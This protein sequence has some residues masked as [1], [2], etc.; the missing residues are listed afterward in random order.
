MWVIGAQ[1]AGKSSLINALRRDFKQ[2]AHCDGDDA[3]AKPLP[4]FIQ[5][6]SEAPAECFQPITE[7]AVP[8]TTVGF[9]RLDG[10]LPSRRCR[11]WDTPGFE[12]SVQLSSTAFGL[13][14]DEVRLLL[15]RRSL[16]PRSFR[17]LP[18]QAL[19][20]GGLARVEVLE[21][22]GSSVYLT[23]WASDEVSLHMG[24]GGAK[25]EE[26]QL[27]YSGTKLV[28]P[29]EH[30]RGSEGESMSLQTQHMFT[31]HDV[32]VSGSSWK[33]S[34]EDVH[35]AGLGWVAVGL[36]GRARLRVWTVDGAGVSVHP[37][38]VPDI[39]RKMER[40]GFTSSNLDRS[41]SKKKSSKHRAG[42][43]RR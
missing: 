15:P 5:R 14:P 7:A 12:N 23:V 30:V 6:E 35:I 38:L 43:G 25:A 29:L 27:K 13:L 32:T 40:P 18:N 1:N 39:S 4:D 28:P 8:G 42:G 31:S 10:V 41:G 3:S 34:S 11:V 36:S 2:S 9:I 24:K 17:V 22:P 37:S 26:I 21:A 33:V 20:L 19:I 16:K